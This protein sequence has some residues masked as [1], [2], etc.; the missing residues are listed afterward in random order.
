MR[1]IAT[2]EPYLRYNTR[3]LLPG[4]EFEARPGFGRIM[5]KLGR[6]VDAPERATPQ[7]AAPQVQATPAAP[8]IDDNDLDALRTRAI[9]LGLTIDQRWGVKRLQSAIKRATGSMV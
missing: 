3:R 5:K 4:E 2:K 7:A 6:A 8:Q 1:L 9:A